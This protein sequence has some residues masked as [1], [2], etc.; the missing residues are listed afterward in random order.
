V[1]RDSMGAVT[2]GSS[3][4]VTHSACHSKANM[5]FASCSGTW[6][7]SRENKY[8]SLNFPRSLHKNPTQNNRKGLTGVAILTYECSSM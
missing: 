5:S 2:A 6:R 8:A 1:P 3:Q 7:H 4:S